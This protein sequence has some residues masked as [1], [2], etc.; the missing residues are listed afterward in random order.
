MTKRFT[1]TT[2]ETGELVCPELAGHKLPEWKPEEEVKK[3]GAEL[4][5]S[6]RIK[7]QGEYEDGICNGLEEGFETGYKKAR[8]KYEFTES[9]LRKAVELAK[10]SMGCDNDGV[11]CYSHLSTDE[12]IQSLRTSRQPVAIEV[13]WEDEDDEIPFLGYA[14]LFNPDGT[15]KATYIFN[16]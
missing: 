4:A 3:M 7:F 12:I 15:L 11:T 9:D 16:D 2:S 13:E 1:L 8:E 10:N 6:R 5:Y 14:P